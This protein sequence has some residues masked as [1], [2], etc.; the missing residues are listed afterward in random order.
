MGFHFSLQRVLEYRAQRE[1]EARAAYAM[2]Q[3]TERAA[4][5]S[6]ALVSAELTQ[7][8]ARLCDGDLDNAGR[9]LTECYARGL[10]F[11]AQAAAMRLQE[12]RSLTE[13]RRTE[14]TH[15]A[16]EKGVLDKL[17][18]RRQE[19]YRREEAVQ[20]QKINDEIAAL[21]RAPSPF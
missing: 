15:R 20:E 16:V 5:E 12:S 4:E 8:E 6:F 18:E 14:L 1:E 19:Q 13:E 21:R 3:A 17:K 11:D 7:T 2:A 9:W 10:R